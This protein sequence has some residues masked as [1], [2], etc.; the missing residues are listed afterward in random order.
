[1]QISLRVRFIR[2]HWVKLESTSS[3]VDSVPHRCIF[4]PV[5]ID[6]AGPRLARRPRG[7]LPHQPALL[8]REDTIGSAVPKMAR[9]FSSRDD[10]SRVLNGPLRRPLSASPPTPSTWPRRTRRDTIHV[11][12]LS[13][14]SRGP[15]APLRLPLRVLSTVFPSLLNPLEQE[16]VAPPTA[17]GER[18]GRGNAGSVH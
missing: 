8:L 15:I 2:L 16:T 18:R 9:A 1:M 5:I 4:R 14:L 13:L 7:R 6:G 17:N 10:V 3:S 11:I 12:T